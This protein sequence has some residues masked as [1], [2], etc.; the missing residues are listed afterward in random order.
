M[1]PGERERSTAVRVLGSTIAA[2][3]LVAPMAYQAC[4]HPDGDLNSARAAAE[5]GLGMCLSSLS[6]HDLTDVAAAGPNGLRWYQLYPYRD[7]GMNTEV[8]TRAREAGYRALII[9]V[10]APTYGVRERDVRSGFSVPAH[11]GLPSVPVPPGPGAITPEGVSALMKRDLSWDD[12]AGYIAI[13]DMPVIIKGILHPDDA[14]RVSGLGARGIVVSNH[15]GRQL[16]TAIATIEAL[17]D[18]ADAVGSSLEIYLDSGVRRGT[19]VLK[20]IALGARAVFVG[21][22]VAWANAVGGFECVRTVLAQ[23]VAEAENALT[24]SGCATPREADRGLL[25][26]P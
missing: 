8:I 25:R 7:A 5:L 21:R 9:T 1:L 17:P 6:N 24:L 3:I 4:V 22:P 20:A 16:D 18:I 19:D 12:V 26:L 14:R 23:L 11:L 13:A 15:G 2:P 10:D